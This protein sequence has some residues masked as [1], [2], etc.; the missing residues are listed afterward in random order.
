MRCW[1]GYQSG[2]RCKSSAHGPADATAMPSSLASLKS[3]LVCPC[4]C[5]LTEVVLEKRSL[6]RCLFYVIIGKIGIHY[7][8]PNWWVVWQMLKTEFS[9]MHQ[10]SQW[11]THEMTETRYKFHTRHHQRMWQTGRWSPPRYCSAAVEGRS[12]TPS[13]ALPWHQRPADRSQSDDS[14]ATFKH[15]YIQRGAS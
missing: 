2:A 7:D 5:R 13:P 1:H 8:T 9:V 4:W 3:R 12:A 15:M 10:P 14:L 11:A 6:I